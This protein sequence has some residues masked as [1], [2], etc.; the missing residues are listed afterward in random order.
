MSAVDRLRQNNPA[1]TD[2]SIHLRLEPSD[3]DL[4]LALQQ[5][6]FI[7]DIELHLQWEQRTDWRNLLR[8]IA[9][10][11]NLKTVQLEGVDPTETQ[12]HAMVALVS[13]ILRA[14]QQN[15]AIQDV[16]LIDLRLPVGV[17]TF[18]DTTSSIY[19]FCLWNCDME[20]VEQERGARYLAEA[21]Q[22]NTNIKYLDIRFLD[23]STPPF[24]SCNA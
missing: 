22:R 2:I 14:I 15:S 4:A 11:E 1:I 3:A 5:N 16:A 20:P 7:I 9:K 13:P 10:R 8:V 12:R 24:Q 23:E 6:S 18:L 19:Y 17:A 21:L